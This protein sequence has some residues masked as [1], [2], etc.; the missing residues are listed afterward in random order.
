M[1]PVATIVVLWIT[2]CFKT[3]PSGGVELLVGLLPMH[4]LLYRLAECSCAHTATL[5]HSHPV[6]ILL[7]GTWGGLTLPLGLSLV[8]LGPAVAHHLVS[9]AKDAWVECAEFTETFRATS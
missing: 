1:V 5:G 3:S 8:E 4:L 6:R 2:G 9:P 7:R